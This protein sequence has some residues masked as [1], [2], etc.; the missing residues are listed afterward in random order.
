MLF[1]VTKPRDGWPALVLLG[2]LFVGRWVGE[3]R[4]APD[5]DA[6]P[7]SPL[8]PPEDPAAAQ[9][10]ERRPRAADGP[11]RVSVTGGRAHVIGPGP[12]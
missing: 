10:P 2:L 8:V 7:A 4:G 11:Q 5:A 3:S 9:L 6:P 12:M 1:K